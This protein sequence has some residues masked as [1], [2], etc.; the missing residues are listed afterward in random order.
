MSLFNK[1][2]GSTAL[3]TAAAAPAAQGSGAEQQPGGAAAPSAELSEERVEAALQAARAEGRAEG[4]EAG[5]QQ[6]RDRTAAVFATAEGKANMG[7]AAWMLGANPT[8][9][10]DAISAQLKSMP[11]AAA[12]STPAPAAALTTPLTETPQADLTGKKPAGASTD[13]AGDVEDHAKMWDSV[14][15]TSRE[16]F[17]GSFAGPSPAIA[18]GGAGAAVPTRTGF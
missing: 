11:A 4:L 14:Q 12:T 9:T 1:L 8:A 5:A 6:E 3:T 16:R 13:G 2:L 15:A 7:M 17:L 18:H 10:A